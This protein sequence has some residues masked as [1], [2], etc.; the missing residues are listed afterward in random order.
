MR[1]VPTYCLREGM[2]LGDN[3]YSNSGDLMLSCGT[4]LTG[5]YVKSIERLQYN[6]VYID[7]DISKDIP[8]ITVINDSVRAQTVKGIKD[9][10]IHCEKG[11]K[12]V[13]NDFKSAKLQIENIVDEIFK[14]RNLMVNMIDMKVFDDYTY[15][16][17]VNVAVLSIVLGVALDMD[18]D[19][20][21][22]LGFAA[23]LHDI[24]KVFINKDIL[25]KK[26]QLTHTEFE[27][28]KTHSLLGCNHIKKGY[29]VS[30]AAY[31]G[32]LD[33]HEKYEGG[34]Y[35]NNL[36]GERISWYGRIIAVADV[37]DALTSD[38]PYRKSLLPSDAMEYI[39]AS[40]MTLFDPRVVEV[41]VKKIA[42]YPI[43]TCVRLSNGLTG[44]VVE[45]YE[46]LCM[47][48]RVR[49]FMDKEQQDID[50]Y[51]IELADYQSLNITVIEIV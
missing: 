38:R 15:Y 5:E 50:P 51:E 7:D 18:R 30:N 28:I 43:G 24:G 35:P 8:I 34:G 19:E 14:N 22:N 46:D 47:R 12:N 26:G 31:M 16:H 33:H 32:I 23:L 25:N 11:N 44:I 6:G 37:Y 1:F 27:E 45:N 13:K 2:I 42:P 36:Q 49:I 21:C 40:T 39:M 9:I 20:L 4:V 3:L 10:F 48:P 29:G 17:S 41:F